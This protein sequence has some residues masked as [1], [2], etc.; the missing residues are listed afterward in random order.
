MEQF[1]PILLFLSIAEKF[2]ISLLIYILINL[3]VR[4]KRFVFLS[5]IAG[6]ATLYVRMLSLSSLTA[7]A[8]CLLLY[9]FFLKQFYGLSYRAGALVSGLSL[10]VYIFLE[11]V[12]LPLSVLLS[13][14][15]LETVRHS[16]YLLGIFFLPQTIIMCSLA[17]I[18]WKK[19]FTWGN[20]LELPD[21]EL[22]GII[23]GHLDI[24]REKKITNNM[25]LVVFFIVFQGLFNISLNWQK[26][27][28]E[29]IGLEHLTTSRAFANTAVIILTMVS[30]FLVQYL[31]DML[32][33]Q[34]KETADLLVET[35]RQQLNWELRMQ[36][37][38]YN[39]H[40]GMLNMMLKL[41]KAREA[42]DYLQGVVD[43]LE[44]IEEIIKT[45]NQALNALLYSKIARA[46]KR[47]VE[48]AIFVETPLSPCFVSDWDL[49]RIMGNLLDNAIEAL[50]NKPSRRR[51]EVLI[52]GSEQYNR[53]EVKTMGALIP[54]QIEKEVFNRGYSTK[55]EMGHGLGL[56]ICKEIVEKYNGHIL[57][58]RDEQEVANT[59]IVKLPV[60]AA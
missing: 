25:Y 46:K 6:L 24:T 55:K 13:G 51:V 54:A 60:A 35:S 23:G 2:L 29:V 38:D 9:V 33:L 52:S 37:H 11:S 56:A 17:W 5:I 8:I 18:L 15:S 43:D 42:R 32:K 50:Q 30:I 49:N 19:D 20:S 16:S 21:D 3:R 40:L 59:F 27:L 58:N 57:L 36:S 12:L 45:G 7:V 31:V 14:L 39:H 41:G 1:S 10:I 26:R 22:N 28:S 48:I 53:I 34:R 47:G 4:D 44:N